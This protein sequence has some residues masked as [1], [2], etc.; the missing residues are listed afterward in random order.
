MSFR[1]FVGL[2]ISTTA[3]AVPTASDMA[4]GEL[5]FNVASE[6]VYTRFGTT[7]ADITDRYTQAQINDLLAGKAD[8]SHS[9][10]WGEIASKPATAT[11][12]PAFAE[13]TDKP[14]TYTPSTHG[15]PLSQITETSALKILT[16]DERTKLSAVGTMANRDV[17]IS[18]QPP[19]PGTGQD[20]DIWLQHWS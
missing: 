6:R 14:A 2:R 19:D 8:A 17:T 5:A 10:P 1:Q 4:E 11:R 7:I 18:D 3:G 9:H 12:W 15:H 20:G 16:A 13:V